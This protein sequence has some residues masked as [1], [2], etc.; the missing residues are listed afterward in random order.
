MRRLLAVLMALLLVGFSV[1]DGFTEEAPKKSDSSE[2]EALKARVDE[3]EKKAKATEVVD[4]LGHKLHPIH[5]IYGLKISGGVTITAQG[6]SHIKGT[7]TRGAAAISADL[8]LESP[9]GRDGRA[10][11]VLDFQRGTGIAGLPPFFAGP[12][13]NP[14]GFNADI[15]SFNNDTVHLTQAYYEHNIGANLVVSVGQLD[16]TGY[17]DTNEFANNERTQFLA[18]IFVNNSTIEFGGTENFYSPGVRVTFWPAENVDITLG[19]FEG[20]GDYADTFDNP[21]LIG[22]VNVKLKPG[23]LDGNYRAYYWMRKGRPDNLSTADTSDA[24]LIKA[25]NKGFGV[26]FDQRITED[27][28]AWFRGGI[29][30]EKVAQFDRSISGGIN[31]SVSKIGRPNDNIGLGYGVS[32][33][34]K[35]YKDFKQ[36][37]GAFDAGNE[38]YAELYYNYAINEAG[39]NNGFH[40]SP[41]IQYV[42]NPGGDRNASKFFIYGIR[43]QAFF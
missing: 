8:A 1:D 28:G 39:Q 17:F 36:A 10:V 41:D 15:E 38:H 2:I 37:N 42:I 5:S 20:N 33:I 30:R 4:E 3:L 43:L 27:L 24:G 16:I 7:N 34:S 9:I 22:E 35:V 6:A 21:F 12:N 13:A 11:A 40:I 26:S 23:G 31:L 19:A 32:F 18:N 29:Q 14:T 25:E